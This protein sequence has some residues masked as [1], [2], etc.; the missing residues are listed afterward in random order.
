MKLGMKN[1]SHKASN[2]LSDW[3]KNEGFSNNDLKHSNI[4]F[5]SPLKQGPKNLQDMHG[6]SEHELLQQFCKKFLSPLLKKM[7]DSSNESLID[8]RLSGMSDSKLKP[9][10]E[11]DI[12]LWLATE[13]SMGLVR[14]PNKHLHWA[15][16]P[17]VS[18]QGLYGTEL[19]KKNIS[20]NRYEELEKRI[21][22]EDKEVHQWFNN[23]SK[24]YWNIDSI[25][26]LDD[27]LY[28]WQGFGGHKVK[29]DKKAAGTGIKAWL[30]TDCNHYTYWLMF[31]HD[32][33]RYDGYP[34]NTYLVDTVDD[35]LPPGPYL[36]VADAGTVGSYSNAK[37]LVE[38][39]RRVL[40]SCQAKRSAELY[41]NYLHKCL[42][43]GNY[44]VIHSPTLTAISWWVSGS[45]SKKK[46]VNFITTEASLVQEDIIA[47]YDK[48]IFQEKEVVVPQHA[49]FIIISIIMLIVYMHQ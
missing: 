41:K 48:K 3:L 30:L 31:E 12:R 42:T 40:M 39:N 20:R 29:I 11:Y 46:I 19:I 35:E 7:I 37:K 22:I 23:T 25:V 44:T 28:S 34:L 5:S 45:G 14:L 17:Y 26:S 4:S 13:L 32:M 16:Q 9:L 27:D 18:I 49:L 8:A 33:K 1:K 43:I 36:I 24:F 15:D 10:E 6:L 47:E 21:T 2:P 38:N